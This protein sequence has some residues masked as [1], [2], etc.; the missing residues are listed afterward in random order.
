MILDSCE[1]KKKDHVVVCRRYPFVVIVVNHG[2][3][4]SETS[5]YSVLAQSRV[6]AILFL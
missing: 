3:C 2:M 1:E 5:S 4:F 6:D